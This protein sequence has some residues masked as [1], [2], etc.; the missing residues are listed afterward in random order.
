MQYR[1]DFSPGMPSYAELVIGR[2]NR[3]VVDRLQDNRAWPGAWL[4]LVGPARSGRSTLAAIWAGERAGTV[5]GPGTLASASLPGSGTALAGRLA[6]DDAD[7]I[8]DEDRLLYVLNLARSAGGQVLLTAEAP[9]ASWPVS[10]PDLV[11]R[12][13][14][15]PVI[16]IDLPD[17]AMLHDLFEAACHRRHLGL[18]DEV[19]GYI[20]R[21]VPRDYAAIETLAGEICNAVA[22]TGRGLTVPVVR[23][24]LGDTDGAGADGEEEDD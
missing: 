6:L 22:G 21:R 15:M 8:T 11:S 18:P 12:L 5:F 4:C 9:P 23:Q 3:H 19:W 20:S 7:A 17:E 14:A 2:S 24:V 1:F 13:R 10:Q 16:T